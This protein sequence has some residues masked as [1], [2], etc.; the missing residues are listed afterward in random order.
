M[1]PPHD[2]APR[3]RRRQIR[4]GGL[5]AALGLGLTFAL[6]TRGLRA[7]GPGFMGA[8]SAAAVNAW[9]EPKTSARRRAIRLVVWFGLAA[10]VALF[11]ALKLLT[12]RHSA[13][14]IAGDVVAV[15]ALISLVLAVKLMGRRAG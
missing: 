9:L 3:E 14:R 12:P 4:I 13:A 2:V 11:L 8:G 5:I 7:I 1:Q 10:L 6:E 15:L